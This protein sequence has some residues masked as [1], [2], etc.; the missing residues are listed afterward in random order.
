TVL[1]FDG[2]SPGPGRTA[3]DRAMRR[4]FAI[5]GAS[6]GV[7]FAGGTDRGLARAL[8]R[9]AGVPDDDG[10]IDRLLAAYLTE[11]EDVLLTRCYR[12]VGDVVTTVDA[13]RA[14][15]AVV[16]VGTGN[17]RAG[18]ALKLRSAGLL[19][20]FDLDRGG[21]GCDGEPREEILRAAARR[22]AAVSSASS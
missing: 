6:S 7:R 12:P 16:G 20:S 10:A 1:T 9:R 4:L 3:L 19:A 2:P 18:A 11:L 15:G 5:D 17:L 13:C 21:Y 14:R 8:L 22:C